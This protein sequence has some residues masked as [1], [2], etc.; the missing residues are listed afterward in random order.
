MRG[1]GPIL[2]GGTTRSEAADHLTVYP[3]TNHVDAIMFDLC[4]RAIGKRYPAADLEKLF[5]SG[6]GICAAASLL[7][8]TGNS[9]DPLGHG[10]SDGDPDAFGF[11]LP[12]TLVPVPWGVP[13]GA[14]VLLELKRPG[15]G[16]EV[17]FE[18]RRILN[19][20]VERL[21]ADGLH[22]VCAA[23]LEFYFIGMNR[24]DGGAPEP[25]PSP[26]TGRPA[27][28]KQ[29]YG[30]DKLEEFGPILA[31]IEAA[32]RLQRIPATV[33][34]A[35]FAPGQFEINLAH[36]ADPLVAADHAC[37]LR[38][39]VRCVAREH[40]ID[41]TF[42]SKPFSEESGSGLHI[43]VS[44]LD[45]Q[46]AAVFGGAD[47]DDMLSF[48]ISGLQETMAEGMA[49][50]CPSLHGF[51]RFEANQF[52]PVT[53]DWGYDNRS[54]AFRIP[55]G[56]GTARRI[57]HRIAGADAN[58][59]L[60]L[61]AVLA[62]LHFGMTN[63]RATRSEAH[64]GNA[65]EEMA[66]D[67]PFTPWESFAALKNGSILRDYL[68]SKYVDAYLTVKENE[69]LDLLATPSPREYEWYI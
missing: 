61:A 2:P 45:D 16:G 28:A 15:D 65:G 23:E 58:P 10:F 66:V 67:L 47:G 5:T 62:G 37:L 13:G 64:S 36:V 50:F 6:M 46:E 31:D 17:W 27:T 55:N 40:G 12:E 54:V 11:P 32:C 43:H 42:M 38:R 30:M 21:A 69:F 9:S 8:V 39:V 3:D 57:E 29:V 41:A 48:A 52:V 68:G 7:D 25:V 33:A 35:E 14:Q 20:V 26:L 22:P 49:V 60:V 18:P 63:R 51:R 19:R 24:G 59:Y 4:G 53:R 1:N 34:S 44:V 56:E